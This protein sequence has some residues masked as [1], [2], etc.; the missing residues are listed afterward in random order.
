MNKRGIKTINTLK[1]EVIVA[2]KERG[3]KDEIISMWLE[4]IE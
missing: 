2:L 3:Y 4:H 1:E